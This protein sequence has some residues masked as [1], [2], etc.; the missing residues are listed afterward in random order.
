MSL[1]L[2]FLLIYPDI[3]QEMFSH[4]SEFPRVQA[5]YRGN[6]MKLSNNTG[7]FLALPA[8][9]DPATPKQR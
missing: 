5:S 9:L 3:T 1:Y 8:M 2:I 4:F 6:T 7:V